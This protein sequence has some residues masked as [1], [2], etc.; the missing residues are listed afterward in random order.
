MFLENEDVK[1]KEN[2]D[3]KGFLITQSELLSGGIESN[4]I[5]FFSE[6]SL[7]LINECA[8]LCNDQTIKPVEISIN[9]SLFIA[10]I[11]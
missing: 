2:Y 4:Q 10:I 3:E 5:H 8:L 9:D 6:A 11:E 1:K 7:N